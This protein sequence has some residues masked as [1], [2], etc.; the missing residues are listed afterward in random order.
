MKQFITAILS[1]GLLTGLVAQDQ[2]DNPKAKQE[3]RQ[4]EIRQQF[5]IEGDGNLQIIIEQGGEIIQNL[6]AKD[7]KEIE[8]Q[9]RKHVDGNEPLIIINGEKVEGLPKNLNK[10][11]RER[12]KN[13]LK[14][15]NKQL[16]D[17]FDKDGDGK[18][19]KDEKKAAEEAMDKGFEEGLNQVNKMLKQFNNGDLDIQNIQNFDFRRFNNR[20]EIPGLKEQLERDAFPGEGDF[21]KKPKDD[22]HFEGVL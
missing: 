20:N 19:N 11:I 3:K 9:I 8:A 7:R 1:I 13:Q 22:E 5:K 2:D 4:K 12:M 17:R 16:L 15:P 21:K 14:N 6:D 18:L 10:M